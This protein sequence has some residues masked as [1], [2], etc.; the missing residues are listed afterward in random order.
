MP[1]ST[2]R[3]FAMLQT[4]ELLDN[5]VFAMHEALRLRTPEAV[6]RMRVSVRRLQQALTLFEQYYPKPVVK[7]IR[8]QLKVVMRAAGDLRNRDI[9]IELLTQSGHD[10]PQLKKSRGAAKREL[11]ETL[12]AVLRQDVG[13]KW[14]A[15]LRLQT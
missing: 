3:E 7:K 13:A 11:R 15:G 4:A 8:K 5:L 2:M 9:A 14:R 6:H 10:L 1:A 12:R